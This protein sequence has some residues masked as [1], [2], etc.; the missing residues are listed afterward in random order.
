[1]PVRSVYSEGGNNYRREEL[2]QA[3]RPFSWFLV[4]QFLFDVCVR[5]GRGWS[6]WRG[7]VHES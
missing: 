6:W 7:G 3:G 4:F 2:E 1:M 5:V